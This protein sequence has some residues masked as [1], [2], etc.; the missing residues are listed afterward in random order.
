MSPSKE[1]T[2]LLSN[3]DIF[4]PL[5]PEE[6]RRLYSQMLDARFVPGDI[7]YT[8]R[9]DSG[10]LYVLR[11]GRVRVYIADTGGH[12][13]TLAVVD[14]G[15]IFGEM[16]LTAQRRQGA[17]AQAME[18]SEVSVLRREDLEHL[19]LDKPEVGLRIARLLS[20]RLRS[21][22]TRL[23]DLALKNVAG[24]LASLILLLLDIEGEVSDRGNLRIPTHYTHQQLGTM[25]GASRE[26][27][28]RAFARLQDEGAVELRRRLICVEDVRAL[29][30]IAGGG[31]NQDEQT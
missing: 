31:S 21:H 12:E 29:R 5:S 27:V 26:Q 23:G 20:E 30:R 28:T 15:T 7:V 10:K 9:D 19:I 3:T 24:R 22:E 14:A 16:A 2:Q 17:Y 4:Q 25:I 11:R 13:F 1:T 6:I 18:P 8:P